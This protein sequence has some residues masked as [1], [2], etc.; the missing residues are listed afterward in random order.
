V[1]ERSIL[2]EILGLLESCG[3]KIRKELLDGSGGGLCRIQGERVLFLDRQAKSD[4]L[5]AV[6]AEAV[7]KVVDIEKIY[8]RPEVRSFIEN[9]VANRKAGKQ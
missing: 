7:L 3:V 9:Q 8:M 2:E 5:A 4:E 1:D 6:C